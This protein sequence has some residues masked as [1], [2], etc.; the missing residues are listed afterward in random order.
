MAVLETL[1]ERTTN[2]KMAF[3]SRSIFEAIWLDGA[4]VG[5]CIVLNGS[6]IWAGTSL[7]RSSCPSRLS[8]SLWR[9]V[10]SRQWCPKNV[11]TRKLHSGQKSR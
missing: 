1:F 3:A 10:S 6:A 4:H 9:D 7:Y 11:I 2:N 8:G 5:E